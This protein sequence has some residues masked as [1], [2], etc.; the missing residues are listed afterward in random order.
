MHSANYADIAVYTNRI[1]N[2]SRNWRPI[3]NQRRQDMY[4]Y[5]V[6]PHAWRC[7][8][9]VAD[10]FFASCTSN[11]AVFTSDPHG[12]VKSVV[13]YSCILQSH[14][15]LMSCTVPAGLFIRQ[16]RYRAQTSKNTPN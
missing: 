15:S 7:F 5:S 4:V 13:V 16:R 11:E 9:C 1:L 8:F 3:C 12:R 10:G 14:T 2:D 6:A